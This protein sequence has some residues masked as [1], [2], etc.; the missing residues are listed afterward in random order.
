MDVVFT[1]KKERARMPTPPNPQ[2]ATTQRAGDG[3]WSDARLS[4]VVE[5]A[6]ILQAVRR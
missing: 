1:D 6:Y 4:A 2:P 5:A 3:S